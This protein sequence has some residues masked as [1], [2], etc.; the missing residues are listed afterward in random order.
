MQ[1]MAEQWF[2]ESASIVSGTSQTNCNMYQHVNTGGT[3][4]GDCG[5]SRSAGLGAAERA[6]SQTDETQKTFNSWKHVSKSDKDV[7]SLKANN[8]FPFFLIISHPT[9]STWCT[10][11]PCVEWA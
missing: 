1:S 2:T 8:V 11:K 6:P 9:W 10:R 3:C 5:S 4:P 7:N